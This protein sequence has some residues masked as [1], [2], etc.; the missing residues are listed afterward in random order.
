MREHS[1]MGPN[2]CARPG[3]IVF[4]QFFSSFTLQ[5]PI[6]SLKRAMVRPPSLPEPNVE[7]NEAPLSHPLSPSQA[8]PPPP[9][10]AGSPLTNDSMFTPSALLVKALLCDD[11]DDNCSQGNVS[12]EERMERGK[13]KGRRSKQHPKLGGQSS[14]GG[15]PSAQPSL[16]TILRQVQPPSTRTGQF[17]RQQEVKMQRIR[18]VLL[19]SLSIN[20]VCG[21]MSAIMTGNVHE[22]T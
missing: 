10:A 22:D 2:I 11:K 5:I 6:Y 12:A 20:L 19:A 13:N 15:S 17:H 7:D 21:F 8:S 4:H 16:Q 3:C 9:S 1:A 18:G 14:L